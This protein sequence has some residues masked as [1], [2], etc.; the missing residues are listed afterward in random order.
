MAK[1]YSISEKATL[2]AAYA[3]SGQ[4]M[5]EFSRS[6]GVSVITLRNWQ[7]SE[8]AAELNGFEAIERPGIAVFE[9]FR[10]VVGCA[11][12]ECATLPPA[13]WVSELIK[14]LGV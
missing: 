4:R 9:G 13:Q 5:S 3:S 14:R 11:T 6:C 10:L 1:R 8:Q 7:R 12:V 2:L